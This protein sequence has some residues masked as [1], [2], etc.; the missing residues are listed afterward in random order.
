M[1]LEHKIPTISDLMEIPLDGFINLAVNDC[2]YE[3]K[4]KELIVNWVHPLSLKA[5]S[6]ASKE[7]TPTGTRQ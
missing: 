3:G 6:E 7:D 4:T 1:S 5:H 2:V